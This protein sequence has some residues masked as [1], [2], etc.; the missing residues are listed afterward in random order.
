MFGGSI[1][2]GIAG[3]GGAFSTFRMGERYGSDGI[4][5]DWNCFEL[6]R[7]VDGASTE[8]KSATSTRADMKKSE[9]LPYLSM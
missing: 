5:V 8:Q 9:T 1:W 2:R 7:R 3:C 4:F 6:S